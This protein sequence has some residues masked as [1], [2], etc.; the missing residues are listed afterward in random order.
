MAELERFQWYRGWY[1]VG[2]RQ[3]LVESG[4]VPE[5]VPFPGDLPGVRG[6][7]FT[8]DDG[9]RVSI[10]KGAAGRFQVKFHMSDAEIGAAARQKQADERREK[11]GQQL[12]A[13]PT[14]AAQY[15]ERVERRLLAMVEHFVPTMTDWCGAYRYTDAALC[16]LQDSLAEVLQRL[17]TLP[18]VVDECRVKNLQRELDATSDQA[19]QGLLGRVL[20]G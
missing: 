2:T 5:S 15:R 1:Y 16:D 19:L 13:I 20:A 8:A 4:F 18:V 10:C 9:R 12:H 17:Q 11:I 14:D 7:K 6:S 3:E